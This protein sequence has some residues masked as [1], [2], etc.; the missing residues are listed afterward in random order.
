VQS[1]NGRTLVAGAPSNPSFNAQW[2]G[3]PAGSIDPTN[4]YLRLMIDGTHQYVHRIVWLHTKGR[5]PEQ[6]LDHIDGDKTNCAIWN[7]RPSSGLRSSM[8][9]RRRTGSCRSGVS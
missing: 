4:G 2:A 8:S 1:R 3:K 7:L 5:L 9:S 6:D